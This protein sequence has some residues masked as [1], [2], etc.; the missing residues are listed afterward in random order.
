MTA[1]SSKPK[2]LLD[3]VREKCRLKHFS[4]RTEEA[5]SGW[6]RRFVVYH[7]K[8]HPRE[9]GEV[10][11]TAFLTD[12]AVNGQVAASTQNQALA[13]LLFL[14]EVVIER[15]LSR[16]DALR[17]NRPKRLPIVLSQDEVR[18]LL[19]E[20]SGVHRAIAR[21]M[22]GCGLRLLECMRLRVK[23]LEFDL[24]QIVVREGKGDKDRRTMLPQ[25]LREP[26]REHLTSVYSLHVVDLNA[27]FGAVYLPYAFARKDASAATDWEWQ[28]V[29]PSSR[30]S[31]DPRTNIKRRHH[32][33]E[34]A[35]NR[36]FAKAAERAKFTKRVTSH[37]LRHSFATHLLESGTDIRT[38][39]ELLGHADVETTMIYTHVLN[40]GGRGVPSPLDQLG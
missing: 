7:G 12:L 40:K 3:V 39:Q 5:Y 22:Y 10:E 29:F 8:R 25:I 33:D 19:N 36:V 13:A 21:L 35:V 9:L 27:G 28:Y 6:I 4:I 2:M 34:N 38:I 20:L 18:R 30:L 23:D 17:A 31:V 11:V 24:G 37:S 1:I 15:P 16:V 32:L 14:Y 26:L